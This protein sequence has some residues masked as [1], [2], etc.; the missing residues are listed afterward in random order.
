[1]P[2]FFD[3]NDLTEAQRARYDWAVAEY[4]RIQEENR[5][6]LEQ[7]GKQAVPH[8]IGPKS[9]LFARLLDGKEPLPHPP[10]TSYSYPWYDIIEKSGPHHVSIGGGLSV[11]GKA[12]WDDGLGAN[13]RILLNQCP[14]NILRKNEGATEFLEFLQQASEHMLV[15]GKALSVVQPILD[16]KPEYVV[17]YGKWGEFHLSLGRIVRRGRREFVR[18]SQFDLNTLDG[19]NAVIVR[20]LVSGADIRSKSDATLATVRNR[21]GQPDAALT[22]FD[23]ILLASESA[24]PRSDDPEGDDL[25]E[26]DC[27]GWILKKI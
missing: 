12:H 18:S 15:P 19:G 4:N 8:Q 27:D 22:A 17:T 1:M 13:E 6:R 25:V 5:L 14:W 24:I 26:F 23:Q 21:L 10:P 20:V 16:K 11:A 7:A 9:A 3:E 2:T